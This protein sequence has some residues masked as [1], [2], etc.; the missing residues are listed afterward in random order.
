MIALSVALALVF[1]AEP[2]PAK[3]VAQLATAPDAERK[4]L[5]ARIEALGRKA[6]PALVEAKR[7]DD[8]ELRRRAAAL[9]EKLEAGLLIRP[10]V[11]TLDFQERPL[12]DVVASIA[13]RSGIALALEPPNDPAW[14]TVRVT[15][16]EAQPLPFWEALERIGQ[17]GRLHHN[18]AFARRADERKV[19]LHLEQGALTFPQ[20]VSGPFRVSLLS[21]HRRHD[22]AFGPRDMDDED[23]AP[24][25]ERFDVIAQVFAEPPLLITLNGPPKE[26]KARD[27][28]DQDLVPPPQEPDD[29]AD[30]PAE[31]EAP[32][33]A[34]PG[35][36]PSPGTL[37]VVQLPIALHA[38][39]RPG[40]TI[41]TLAGYIPLQVALRRP[42]PLAVAL[43]QAS[44]RTFEAEDMSV[45][46]ADGKPELTSR[47]ALE[48]FVTWK[49]RADALV[50]DETMAPPE[51]PELRPVDTLQNRLDV[52]DAEGRPLAYRLKDVQTDDAGES[53]VLIVLGAKESGARPVE[54]RFYS[55]ITGAIEIPFKFANIPLP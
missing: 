13:A 53:R 33:R 52:V 9:L 16:K 10:S 45:R 5:A 4:A 12:T 26:L 42:A 34:E 2:E 23:E 15:L 41:M 48:L 14:G 17:A 35:P 32:P 28:F 1:A 18:P 11:V 8:P 50:P 27:D 7:S 30:A 51:F 37:S 55:L 31:P 40:T 36:A 49:T 24:E 3:L 39:E 22:A 19:L 20:S 54:L 6:L 47:A 25:P 43:A 38:P 46:F 29:D 21:A 44:G